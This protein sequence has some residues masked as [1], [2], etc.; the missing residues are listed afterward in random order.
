MGSVLKKRKARMRRK[1]YR[2]RLKRTRWQ[3]R[4]LKK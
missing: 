1:K 4:A 2:K 3:R